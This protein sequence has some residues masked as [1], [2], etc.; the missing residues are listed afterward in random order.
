MNAALRIAD[1]PGQPLVPDEDIAR[2]LDPPA[3]DDMINQ[4]LAI[5]GGITLDGSG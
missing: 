4:V 2:F 5:P 1:R 3:Q